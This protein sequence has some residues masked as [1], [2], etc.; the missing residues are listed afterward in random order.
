MLLSVPLDLREYSKSSVSSLFSLYIPHYHPVRESGS[1]KWRPTKVTT[2]TPCGFQED[3][4]RFR[5][6]P[7]D[8]NKA[9]REVED[10][11]PGKRGNTADIQTEGSAAPITPAGKPRPEVHLPKEVK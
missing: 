9:S 10:R 3:S 6:D 2:E 1:H 11:F 8:V 5:N 4:E 7:A